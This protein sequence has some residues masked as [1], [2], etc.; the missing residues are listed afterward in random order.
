MGTNSL[1]QFEKGNII[2]LIINNKVNTN[3]IYQILE[4]DCETYGSMITGH[5]NVYYA[6]LADM[7][8]ENVF[9]TIITSINLLT[10]RS[11]N[12]AVKVLD[13]N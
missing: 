13:V 7:S 3:K 5:Q 4:I 11:E 1:I 8:G 2:Y 9:R 10:E 6:L 12:Y